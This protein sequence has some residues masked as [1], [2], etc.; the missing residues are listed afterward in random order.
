MDKIRFAYQ[1]KLDDVNNSFGI[2]RST[3]YISSLR[4]NTGAKKQRKYRKLTNR[5]QTTISRLSWCQ[6]LGFLGDLFP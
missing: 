6:P 4:F 3:N 2:M 1:Q 5:E